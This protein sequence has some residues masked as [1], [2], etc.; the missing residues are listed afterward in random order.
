MEDNLFQIGFGD[1][2][3]M[4]IQICQRTDQ[5]VR[6]PVIQETDGSVGFRPVPDIGQ[7]IRL[8]VSP[9]GDAA[10]AGFALVGCLSRCLKPLKR[11]TE[12]R[13]RFR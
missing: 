11:K 7:G 13:L 6:F 12:L 9:E 1:S 3:F 5:F 8:K 4:D 10:G 2:Q